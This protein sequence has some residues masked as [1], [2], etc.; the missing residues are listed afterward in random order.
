MESRGGKVFYA[1]EAEVIQPLVL[2]RLPDPR[3]KNTGEWW[4]EVKANHLG[5][6]NSLFKNL[7]NTRACLALWPD[8]RP[9]PI[10]CQWEDAQEELKLAHLTIEYAGTPE[11]LTRWQNAVRGFTGAGRMFLIASLEARDKWTK[12]MAKY[13]GILCG[14]FHLQ[15]PCKIQ[16]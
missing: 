3:R 12:A 15:V 11:D 2:Y 4:T 5:N 13:G 8:A 14:K 16:I 9:S 6:P 10:F 7:G 1:P